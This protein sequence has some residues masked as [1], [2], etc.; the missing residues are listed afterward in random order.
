MREW[1]FIS[2]MNGDSI[3]TIS[4]VWLWVKWLYCYPGDVVV[5]GILEGFPSVAGFFEMDQS[6]YGNWF[7]VITSIPLW[8]MIFFLIFSKTMWKSA[9]KNEGKPFWKWQ[10]GFW[11]SMI[12]A[13]GL[14]GLIVYLATRI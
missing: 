10:Y 4:D 12:L 11:P 13:Y 1:K 3:T 5:F 14:L 7:S 9:H 6:S 2:D 8:G